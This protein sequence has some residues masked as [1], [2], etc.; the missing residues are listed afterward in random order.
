MAH[1]HDS[2][3]QAADAEE[4]RMADADEI[5]PPQEGFPA[6]E[7]V[8]TARPAE[9][10]AEQSEETTAAETPQTLE[11]TTV[12]DVHPPHEGIHNWRQYLLH[13]ST[14][15][16]GLLI[17]IGL[18][19]SVEAIHR[20][21]E[22]ADLRES[23]RRETEQAIANAQSSEQAE[24]PSLRWL[25]DRQQL[26][27]DALRAHRTLTG[28]LPRAPHV[29]STMPT[30]PAWAAAKSSGLLSLLTQ[31]EV[32]VYSQADLLL[33]Q[34]AQEFSLG[35][36]ASGKR[37][38]FE[39]KFMDPNNNDRIELSTATPADLDQYRG[40]LLDEDGA[41]YQ[42]RIL[43]EYIRGT[44]TAIRDGE[45]DPAKVHAAQYRFYQRTPR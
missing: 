33:N 27:R 8:D 39:F 25:V 22:R 21:H 15:V 32:E 2:I 37:G 14:I 36:A 20:A 7:L 45:R 43:C 18:E 29:T 19:Q 13:M 23:L 16:L 40:L 10:E 26:V 35:A 6:P 3:S 34:A 4:V 5:P 44:E 12:L 9:T 1:D 30:D 38:Q 31:E 11:D 42:Y 17:A 41:W 24:T 28:S